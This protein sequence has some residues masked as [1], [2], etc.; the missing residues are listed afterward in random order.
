VFLEIMTAPDKSIPRELLEKA[1][2]VVVVP[3]LKKGAF[4]FGAKYGKGFILCR[5]GARGWSA[6]AA[7]RVEGGSF[8]FQISGSETDVVLLVM[9]DRGADKLLSSQFT[10]GGEG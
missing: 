8:G 1:Y 4:I 6:S 7:V 10:L 5:R 9:N 3:G 2:C